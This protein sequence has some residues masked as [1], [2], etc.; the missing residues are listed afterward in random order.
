MKHEIRSW[1]TFTL[2]SKF[3]CVPFSSIKKLWLQRKHIF[4]NLIALHSICYSKNKNKKK[5]K[6]PKRIWMK[7]WLK[8]RNNKN[9]FHNIF[10]VLLFTDK[11]RHYLRMSASIIHWLLYTYALY[12]TYTCNYETC[13]HYFFIYWFLDFTTVHVFHF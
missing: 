3:H 10:S 4:W 8:N 1:S 7:L 11:F 2:I 13:I 6:R 5:S 9:A 12:I